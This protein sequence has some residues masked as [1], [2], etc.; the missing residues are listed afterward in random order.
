[1][2]ELIPC[3]ISQL[4]STNPQPGTALRRTTSLSLKTAQSSNAQL[5]PNVKDQNYCKKNYWKYLAQ[6]GTP[7]PRGLRVRSQ[8]GDT[9]CTKQCYRQAK[10]LPCSKSKW[11]AQMFIIEW[12]NEGSPLSFITLASPNPKAHLLQRNPLLPRVPFPSVQSLQVS[13]WAPS[14]RGPLAPL[15]PL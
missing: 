1:M 7:S 4:N 6:V 11:L 15:A 10:Q 12:Q 9:Q 3:S 14:L 2:Q 13:V 5:H 8:N